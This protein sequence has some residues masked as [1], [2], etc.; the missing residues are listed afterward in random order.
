MNLLYY[1][2]LMAEYKTEGNDFWKGMLL[3]S[4][5]NVYTIL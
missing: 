3:S 2:T 1:P 5:E 4:E